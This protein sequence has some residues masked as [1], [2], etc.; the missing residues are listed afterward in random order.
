MLRALIQPL[1]E[2]GAYDRAAEADKVFLE[3]IASARRRGGV[4]ADRRGRRG[5]AARP[6][7]SRRGALE[8]G[9]A[10]PPHDPARLRQVRAGRPG[11][12]AGAARGL[13][14]QDGR[15][16]YVH[17]DGLSE[18]VV[19]SRSERAILA[20]VEAALAEAAGL[21]RRS[22]GGGAAGQESLL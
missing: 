11:V 10:R 1:T 21:P 16:T 14:R 2:R 8:R 22:R 17:V 4:G 3:D 15:R 19:A 20:D 6:I 7:A 12:R 18:P 5:R 9:Q 13:E